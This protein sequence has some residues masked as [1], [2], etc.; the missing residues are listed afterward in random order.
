MRRDV[1]GELI[2]ARRAIASEVGW[3]ELS[4][5]LQV[6]GEVL[7]SAGVG[8]AVVVELAERPVVSWLLRGLWI[9]FGYP[10]RPRVLQREQFW[11]VRLGVGA[12][13][14]LAQA[15]MVDR[16]GR[17]MR[18]LSPK[19]VSGPREVLAGAWRGAFLI[20]GSIT[21][22]T[23]TR[24]TLRV[25]CPTI[26]VAVA[27]AGAARRLGGQARATTHVQHGHQV[28]MRGGD[29]IAHLFIQI[30]AVTA[31][32]KIRAEMRAKP[33]RPEG[34]RGPE[35]FSTA[36]R[37]RARAA[38]EEMRTKVSHALDALGDRAPQHL[39]EAGRLRIDHPDM[40]LEELAKQV[41]PPLTKDAIAG[42]IR[43]L[44]N[45]ADPT[46]KRR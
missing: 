6:G 37:E 31:A 7:D 28:L 17:R 16:S 46:H 43:R 9:E 34:A 32:E 33:T 3:A 1:V 4:A 29:S 10:A 2:G 12:E 45:L 25:A 44:I 24:H 11:S 8:S 35:S 39:A 41:D 23:T 40:T 14:L 19:I 20:A 27:L 5:A 38:A 26:E 18:G 15:G 22:G 42:R 13:R 21:G 36:N 30:G